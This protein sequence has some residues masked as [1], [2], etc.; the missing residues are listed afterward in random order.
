[1]NYLAGGTNSPIPIPAHYPNDIVSGNG[2]YIVNKNG[3]KYID[4]WMGYGALLFGHADPEIIET[5]RKNIKNGWLFSCQTYAE[6]ELSEIIHK[7]IPSA[8]RVR[9]A[10]TGSDAVA[11]SIRVSRAYTGRKKVLSISGGYHGVHEGMIPSGGALIDL[12]PDLI[13]F[14]DIVS[15]EERLKTKEYACF[16]LEPIL[17]N[18]GCTPPQENYLE[19]I[20]EIC[21]KTDTILVFD[22]IVTG[23]RISIQGAQGFY[24]VVPDVSIFSKAIACGFPLS[25]VCGKK[26]IMETLIPTGDV[27]FAGTFNGNPL[28]LIVSKTVINKMQNC[29]VYIKNEEM[30]SRFRKFIIDQINNFQLSACV[31]GIS[32]MSTIAFGCRSFERG[33]KFEQHDANAYNFFIKEMA[34]RH[35][36]LPPLP[37]E[38]IFLSPVHECV[39]DDI[40]DA[41]K[42]SLEEVKNSYH[43]KTQF[44]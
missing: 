8:E 13:P 33:I 18:S 7:I 12:P 21:N 29:D 3:D 22:E 35:F 16:L 30:G 19:K 44:V 4:L 17:A 32:S 28:S 42:Q 43:K 2:P 23:F 38:T 11:Y 25:V 24:N 26:K 37:T 5:V 15:V 20:R 27:F 34:K 1:M 14:N 9:F 10:T 36:L 41:I 6:K 40:K 39:F 31:Q